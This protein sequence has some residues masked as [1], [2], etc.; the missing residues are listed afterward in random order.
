MD[1]TIIDKIAQQVISWEDETYKLRREHVKLTVEI[2]ML[3]LE[4]IRLN[5]LLHPT[6]QPECKDG[7]LIVTDFDEEDGND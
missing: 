1:H 2:A 6:P 4:V 3:N 7:A 5:S